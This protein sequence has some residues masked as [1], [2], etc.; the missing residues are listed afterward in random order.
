MSRARHAAGAALLACTLPAAWAQLPPPPPPEAAPPFPGAGPQPPVLPT[1]PGMQA[2]GPIPGPPAPSWRIQPGVALTESFSDNLARVP[3]DP[4]RGWITLV[5]PRLHIEHRG[6]HSRVLLDYRHQRSWYSG[7]RDLDQSQNHLNA[8]ADAELVENRLSLEGRAAITQVNR[9]AFQPA[10]VLGA[11]NSD[12]N[13]VETRTVGVSPTFKG[14]LGGAALYQMRV[15]AT[16]VDPQGNGLASVRTTEAVA[17]V[18]SATGS[19]RIG[20]AADASALRAR[21][22]S[23]GTMDD[24]RVRGSLVFAL[25]DQV[26]LSL[27][28]GYESTD[29]AATERETGHTPGGG[30]EWSPSRRTRLA[31]VV[32]RRFFGTG[33]LVTFDHRSA[34]TAWRIA[35]TRES[36]LLARALGSTAGN[37]EAVMRD[38]LVASVPDPVARDAAVRRRLAELGTAPTTITDAFFSSRPFLNRSLEATAAY[39]TPRTTFTVNGAW[40]TQDPLRTDLLI[41]DAF[42]E[43]GRIQVRSGNGSVTHRL[44]PLST[45]TMAASALRSEGSTATAP[46]S[47]EALGTIFFT[48]QLGRHIG[49]SCGYRH[50]R[51]DG[52]ATAGYVENAVFGTIN[53]RL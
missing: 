24:G 42:A 1:L 52:N 18:R 26:R 7:R 11:P 53:V 19:A 12:A 47:R 45:V 39:I 48:T 20:W 46:S 27:V 28:E 36:T 16:Q 31:G 32:E 17:N 13:R 40:R 34:R 33:Y 4:S 44:T 25:S 35:A 2:P 51:Y 41:V 21:S 49:L 30:F 5:E 10:V 38:L 23:F 29:F 50:V 6:A 43:A 3:D 22:S 9:S 14:A 15:N 37:L 8:L